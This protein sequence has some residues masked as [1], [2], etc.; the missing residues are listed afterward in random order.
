MLFEFAE[1]DFYGFWMK[2]MNYPIDIIWLSDDFRVVFIKEN[3]SPASYPE[4][5]MPSAPARYV[6]ETAAGFSEKNNLKIGDKAS[7]SF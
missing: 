3:A 4:T 7:F 5:F 6:L 1:P 2:D